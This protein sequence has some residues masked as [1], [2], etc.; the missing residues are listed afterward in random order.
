[1]GLILKVENMK[2]DVDKRKTGSCKGKF[3]VVGVRPSQ[4]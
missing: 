1:M 4:L 3:G 2:V